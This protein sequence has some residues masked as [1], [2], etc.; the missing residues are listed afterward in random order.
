MTVAL[1]DVDVLVADVETARDGRLTV[2]DDHLAMVAV[3]HKHIDRRPDGVKDRHLDA[4]LAHSAQ[5]ALVLSV[6]GAEVVEHN[7]YVETLLSLGL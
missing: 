7:A 1:P 6:D 4:V 2:D 5:K 3:V